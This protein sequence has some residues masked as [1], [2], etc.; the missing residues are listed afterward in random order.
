M[1]QASSWV[2]A[3]LTAA[4]LGAS[5]GSFGAAHA[6]TP[7]AS[8]LILLPGQP[9]L[10]TASLIATGIRSTL[11]SEWSFRISI[12]TEIVDIDRFATPEAQE[13]RL[14]ELH[15][16]K[17]KD[18]PFDLVITASHS[19]LRFA[20]R[21]RD[22]LWPGVPIVA[23][24]VEERGLGAFTVPPGVTVVTVRFDMEGT[25]R[26]A[27]ALLP[28]TE[29]VALVGG[30]AP[31]D[32]FVH[33]LARKAVRDAGR[34]LE[35]IDLATLS[36]VDQVARVST[37][38]ERTLVLVSSYQ[39]DASGRRLYGLE[40][41]EPLST[42][43]NRPTFNMLG[44]VVGRGIVGGSVIDLEAV[45]REA[46]ALGLRALR[47]EPLP[48]SPVAS[49]VV[50]VPRFDGRQLAR[51]GLDEGRLPA[52]SEVL[53]RQSTLWQQYRWQL[54]AVL[55]VIGIQAALIVALLVLRRH[56]LEAQT[57][58]AARLRFD[59]LVGEIG[60]GLA[61]APAARIDEQ[62]IA[63]L[64]RVCAFFRVDRAELWQSVS[65]GE[66]FDVTHS[67]S[68]DGVPPTPRAVDVTRPEAVMEGAGG[69]PG[70][71]RPFAA[72]PLHDGDR[73]LGFLTLAVARGDR[74]WPADVRQ[75]LRA[76]AEHFASAVVRAR[77]A[78]ALQSSTALT[79]AVVA[80]LPG[81]TAIIDAKGTILQTNEAWASAARN[82]AA[83]MAPRLSVGANYLETCE[84]AIGIPPD[85]GAK[86]AAGVA[87][88]LRGERE[89]FS[90]EYPTPRDGQDRWLELR[91]RRLAHLRGEAAVTYLD[92][93]KRRRDEAAA[94]RDLGEIAHL[95]RVAALG[96]LASSI[97][98]EL[99]QP[100]T[101]ILANAQT[102]RRLLARTPPDLGEVHACVAD[103]ISDDRRAA[104][105]IRHMRGLLK[106]TDFVT[107]PIALNDLAATTVGL[108]TNEALLHGVS[109]EFSPAAALPVVHG[110][111]VQIQQVILNLL[112]NA[113]VAAADGPSVRKVTV[114]TT[115]VPPEYVELG[116]HDSGP[117]IDEGDL[118][119]LFEPFFTT[120][121]DGLGMGLAI[122]RRIIEAH[123]GHLQADNDPAGGATFRIHLRTEPPDGEPR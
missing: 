104:E 89:E 18:R 23:C 75:Q 26:L 118:P 92:V 5:A 33:E 58:L 1:R 62:I 94:Q 63:C 107:A 79:A 120:K 14:R 3:T 80:A 117:G 123:E 57:R 122:A 48:A 19:P 13:N 4:L 40:M 25:L 108:V 39:M 53:Y 72:I 54:V 16:T 55:A 11:L 112:N 65:A 7:Q 49:A 38:P 31:Q 88:V 115:T 101:A 51:W 24:L 69:T 29:R 21:V 44:Q 93:T 68:A 12:E 96:H 74:G 60:A 67:W 35:L 70:G 36:L 111:L 76:V 66:P 8:V 78:A 102:A 47:G 2:R 87:S 28:D 17:Y 43:A 64:Q 95:D 83:A 121:S 15:A 119:R 114:W 20:L 52:G 85:T 109:I 100:L 34:P 30:A 46:A 22:E 105:V 110:D 99:N 82:G 9:G 6:S 59:A 106:K 27:L 71:A 90:L 103:I 81:E 73:P 37:L 45:G 41:I 50:S 84:G 97:A 61:V 42:R 32:R 56:R 10:P 113:I 77:T 116:V 98:H 91:V 86:V